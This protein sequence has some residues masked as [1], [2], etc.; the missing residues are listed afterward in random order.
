MLHELERRQWIERRLSSGD[1][2]SHS[3]FLT[4]AGKG[5]MV[6]IESLAA[7][8]ERQMVKF[9]GPDLRHLLLERLWKFG[10]P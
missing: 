8:H 9:I 1:G 7:R 3:L 10:K 6:R 2:R 4:A 5:V